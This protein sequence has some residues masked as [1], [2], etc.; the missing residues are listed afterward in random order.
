LAAAAAVRAGFDDV[1]VYCLSFADWVRDES[2]PIV[3]E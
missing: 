1:R 3:R 2:C